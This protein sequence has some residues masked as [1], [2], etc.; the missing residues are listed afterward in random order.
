MWIWV[1][2]LWL[3]AG[4]MVLVFRRL[5]AWAD[6][7]PYRSNPADLRWFLPVKVVVKWVVP[8]LVAASVVVPIARGMSSQVVVAWAA[9]VV[10]A[11]L[12]IA[13]VVAIAVAGPLAWR[14]A[15]SDDEAVVQVL[16]RS[17]ALLS[18][19]M[20]DQAAELV[21]DALVRYPDDA[22]LC[23][24]G[25]WLALPEDRSDP[26]AATES[27][28]LARRAAALA[29]NS[30]PILLSAAR[31]M[32]RLHEVADARALL[33]RARSRPIAD[34]PLRAELLHLDGLV[35]TSEG[36]DERAEAALRGAFD[37]EPDGIGHGAELA[38]FLARR[39]RMGEALEVTDK[40]LR[41][42]P[43]D[44]VVIARSKTRS[45]AASTTR[46]KIR[47]LEGT[48]SSVSPTVQAAI[49][50]AGFAAVVLLLARY[51]RPAP[52]VLIGVGGAVLLVVIL[53]L[54]TAL[55]SD[56]LKIAAAVVFV[57]VIA[58]AWAVDL[59]ARRFD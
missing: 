7:T 42:R 12:L 16:Q 35:L 24:H 19:E 20:D 59:A 36:H 37:E 43:D 50:I 5:R 9:A 49:A 33:E 57:T 26:V 39:G 3:L 13:G 2:A 11:A 46:R 27:R 48:S 14:A 53:A 28:E 58:A 8:S 41:H 18:Q 55:H 1:G 30:V 17:R 51:V 25:A 38:D 22:R 23:A 40:A 31:V 10:P 44:R 34:V 56:A 6:T 45:A 52:L 4:V 15:T 47:T 29:P 32:Y 54:A 21:R